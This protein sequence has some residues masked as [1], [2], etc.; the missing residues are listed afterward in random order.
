MLPARR[1]EL[2]L[3]FVFD[4]VVPVGFPHVFSI[5]PFTQME[6][7]WCLAVGWVVFFSSCPWPFSLESMPMDKARV[8]A[9]GL[10]FRGVD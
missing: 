10:T 1:E 8:S 6:R 2:D 5:A 9:S 4:R 3:R 7:G